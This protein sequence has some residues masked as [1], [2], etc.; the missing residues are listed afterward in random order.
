VPRPAFTPSAGFLVALAVLLAIGHAVMAVTATVDKSM[1]SDEIAH[2]TAGHAYNTLGDFRLQPENGNLPQRWSALPAKFAGAPLPPTTLQSW[3]E[4]DVW[5]YGHAFFYGQPN[6]GDVLLF[7][8]RAM[9]AL[10]SAATGLLVF[11]WSRALFGWRGAFVSLLLFVFFPDFLAHGA[12]A[13]S[14]VVMTFFFLA[15]VGAWWRH[16]ERPGAGPAALSAVTFGLACV[17]K[18]SA[19]LLVPM[20]GLS[21]LVWFAGRVRGHGWRGPLLRLGRSAAVH[22]LVGWGTIWLF[23]GFRFG[24]F[25]PELA[26]GA[27]YNH[28]WGWLVTELGWPRELLLGL[29]EWRLLPDAF[30]YGF[31][32]VLQ[33]AKQRG[34]FLNG[35]YSLEGWPW[36]FPYAFAVKST[37]PF[38]L[39][40]AAGAVSGWSRLRPGGMKAALMRLRPLTPLAALFVVYWATSIASHLNIGHRHLLPTYPVLFIAAG[41]LG[42]GF[43]LRRPL[44][45][46]FLGGLVLWHAVESWRIRPHYLAYFNPLAGGPANGWRHLVDSSLDWGQDLPGLSRWLRENGRGE[47]SFLAYFGTGDPR[48]EGIRATLLP[49]LPEVGV[50]RPWHA[51]HA[52]IYAVSAT[53]LQ[54]VYSPVRGDWTLALEGE[55][56][57]L[58]AVEPDLLAYQANPGRRAELLRDA[59]AEN[60]DTAW[61]RYE[62]LR[63]AR[64]CHYLRVRTPDANVGYSILIHRLSEAEVAAATAGSLREWAALIERAAMR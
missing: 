21:A 38:L 1:T 15:A 48:Y 23:Y 18:F 64:L 10:F 16:L 29:R 17:A 37:F 45:A 20:F 60:W 41:V 33:F 58:R 52:G 63:F 3:R 47:K 42:A 61:R 19:P 22:G 56:Q 7:R 54:H 25:A 27:S 55:Y 50:V 31:T 39:L 40:L 6:P 4:A 51:L 24:P 28:G 62:L 2:L 57:Q 14:D 36:F 46:V 5:N 9:V 26:D 35:E 12:L 8:G 44:V 59:P 11:F 30:L 49:T 13:T 32:F 53:M 34:A 43:H